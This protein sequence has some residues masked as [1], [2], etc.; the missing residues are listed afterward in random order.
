MSD[1][2][3]PLISVALISYNQA[4]F[5]REAIESV[6]MQRCAGFNL[7][8]VCGDDSSTDDTFAI[9]EEYRSRYPH[10]VRTFSNESN[11]G[12]NG[13]W[14]KTIQSCK[15]E[16]IA[17]L[18]GDDRWDDPEKLAKQFNLLL[19]NPLASACFSNAEVLLRDG[20]N[21][22][23]RYVN[24]GFKDLDAD[25]FFQL[26]YNPIPTCTILFR[27]TALGGFPEL[28][29]SSPFADWIVHALL[30][31]NGKYIY[32]N[33]CTSSYRQHEGGVWSGIRHEKQL[34]NKL[35]ALKLIMQIVADEYSSQIQLAVKKQLD[36]LLYF[37]RD[38]HNNWKY[39]ITWIELKFS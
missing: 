19:A 33:E 36:Q 9:L 16:F 29:F 4:K 34:R 27:K 13:N 30:I 11:L 38:D 20:T 15:G 3:Q 17:I 1:T 35:V 26:N 23:Y 10:M 5:I 14:A 2:K 8:I 31:Q 28:Y 6:L 22:P 24:D 32:L 39:I 18:E 25:S 21:S 12:V 37:Y 7:E